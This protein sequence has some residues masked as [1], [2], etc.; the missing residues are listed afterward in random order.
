MTKINFLMAP[1]FQMLSISRE[2]FS[3]SFERA[4]L[5]ESN[6]MSFKLNE[7]IKTDNRINVLNDLLE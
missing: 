1:N 5:N 4:Y 7:Y 2:S 6:R 3:R